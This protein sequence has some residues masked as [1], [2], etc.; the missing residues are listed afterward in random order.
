MDGITIRMQFLT[1]AITVKFDEQV[2]VHKLNDWPADVC[3][4]VG[5]EKRTVDA[6]CSRQMSI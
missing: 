2:I 3:T 6:V 1:V 4:S 5:S